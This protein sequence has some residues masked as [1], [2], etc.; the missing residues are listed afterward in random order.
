MTTSHKRRKAIKNKRATDPI[1][2][3]IFD[4]G[5]RVRHVV[6]DR[7]LNLLVLILSNGAII[8]SRISDFPKLSKASDKQLNKW[9]LISEGI[10]IEWPDLDEDLS[11]KG[12]IKSAFMT[13]TLRTLKGDQE[14]ILA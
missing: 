11:L 13:G 4:N 9:S 2:K 7:N 8:K 3:I 1:E 14:S 12:F 5:I 6:V 10:G